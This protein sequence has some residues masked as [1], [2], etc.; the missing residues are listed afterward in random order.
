MCGTARSSIF[1]ASFDATA[2]VSYSHMHAHT[3]MVVPGS[4]PS[5]FCSSNVLFPHAL[6]CMRTPQW[7]C[8]EAHPALPARPPWRLACF[9]GAQPGLRGRSDSCSTCR[10]HARQGQQRPGRRCR[11][12]DHGAEEGDALQAAEDH[13]AEE[14]D[15][16]QAAED[17]GAEEGDAR[18][19]V[20]EQSFPSGFQARLV[21]D[22]TYS[23]WHACSWFRDEVQGPRIWTQS[24]GIL[25]TP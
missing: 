3:S 23:P 10:K 11:R 8:R 5:S 13:G 14:G 25:C 2:H 12:Q 18:E 24:A 16:L 1:D 22:S 7:S 6:T 19:P 15:T 9:P 4:A 17:Y 21:F 20:Q